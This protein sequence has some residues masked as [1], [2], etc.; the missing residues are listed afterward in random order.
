VEKGKPTN[1]YIGYGSLFS[2]ARMDEA[3][4]SS[5]GYERGSGAA[6]L[7]VS[8]LMLRLS[9]GVGRGRAGQDLGPIGAQEMSTRRR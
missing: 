3:D 6:N 4:R 9:D 5:R 2:D 1:V 8:D 7:N